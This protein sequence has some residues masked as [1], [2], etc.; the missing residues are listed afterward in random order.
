L[1]DTLDEM[2]CGL[3]RGLRTQTLIHAPSPARK[4][5]LMGLSGP[6]EY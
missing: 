1:S 4:R 6:S 3:F 2:S 5:P